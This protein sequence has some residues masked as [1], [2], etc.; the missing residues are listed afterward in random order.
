MFLTHLRDQL[1]DQGHPRA[2]SLHEPLSNVRP[3][4]FLQF[5]HGTPRTEVWRGAARRV[6]AARRLRQ[7]RHRGQRGHRPDQHRRGV[8][9]DGLSRQSGRGR[10]RSRRI[11]PA[12]HGPKSGRAQQRFHAAD[13]RDAQ[14]GVRRR[15]RLPTREFMERARAIWEELGLPALD[16]AAAVARLFARRL[17][18]RPGRST[19]AARSPANGKQS[20]KETFARRRGG[21][22]PETPVKSV[23]K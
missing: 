17:E 18:R 19:P 1:G 10:A 8:L 9:V 4:I 11:A 15:S 2:W 13:R 23:K 16:A 14:A 12:G 6:G 7:D 21:L 3:V 20:G 5:A 22:T